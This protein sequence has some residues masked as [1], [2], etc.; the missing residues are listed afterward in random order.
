MASVSCCAGLL[1]WPLLL[2]SSLP[3][4][5]SLGLFL[6]SL[7]LCLHPMSSST[8]RQWHLMAQVADWTGSQRRLL[9][10]LSALSTL[11]LSS[12]ALLSPSAQFTSFPASSLLLPA[13][14]A[15]LQLASSHLLH[16]LGLFSCSTKTELPGLHLP[17]LLGPVL[18]L[19]PVSLLGWWC[20]T[21]PPFHGV[22]LLCSA[23][24][25]TL[26]YVL[27]PAVF[28][29]CH[30]SQCWL[31]RGA[32]SSPTRLPS[33][34]SSFLTDAV[35]LHNILPKK[36]KVLPAGQP[37]VL[38]CATMWHETPEEMRALLTS[39]FNVD[40]EQALPQN[41]D[42][43][44]WEVHVLFDDAI[45]C[46]HATGEIVPNKFL[47]SFCD[48]M[49]VLL[50]ADSDAERMS[51]TPVVVTKTP[52]GGLIVWKLPGGSSLL[53]HLKEKAVIRNKKRWSQCMYFLLFLGH[54]RLPT[55]PHHLDQP[56]DN[57]FILA[58][59]GDVEFSYIG[60]L[61]LVEVRIF[62]INIV[63]F[64]VFCR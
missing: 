37:T 33:L 39:V 57:T 19:L 23:P 12:L 9:S 22:R 38:G 54:P 31:L 5:L 62:C 18:A 4:S 14:L 11:L 32:P 16:W 48:E 49:E 3:W 45:N 60:V 61:R 56:L 10:A 55:S 6:T 43:F 63:L 59:D 51:P 34:Q 1:S 52:Y 24:P 53:C 20:P 64:L 35:L 47:R 17:L 44:R 46:N 8:V 25:S 58:L 36:V 2:P 29:L 28:L 41:Q 21:S 30:A 50:T 42:S 7:G 40:K 13:L 27:L 26:E 15:A